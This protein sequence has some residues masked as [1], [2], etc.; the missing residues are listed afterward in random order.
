MRKLL[1]CLLSLFYISACHVFQSHLDLTA[2]T[3]A[4]PTHIFSGNWQDAWIIHIEDY[5]PETSGK[6]SKAVPVR[7]IFLYNLSAKMMDS[8]ATLTKKQLVSWADCASETS[9]YRGVQK[10]VFAADPTK[11]TYDQLL[12]LIT[13][14][15]TGKWSAKTG[16]SL[17][18]LTAKP[19]IIHRTLFTEWRFGSG[20]M[21]PANLCKAQLV[22]SHR[23]E[24]LNA[25]KVK[26]PLKALQQAR[27][28]QPPICGVALATEKEFAKLSD[29][30]RKAIWRQWWLQD[31]LKAAPKPRSVP[32]NLQHI[33]PNYL[34]TTGEAPLSGD[35]LLKAIQARL[36]S[37]SGN[38][39]IDSALFVLDSIVKKNLD[40]TPRRLPRASDSPG[41]SRSL[42][43]PTREWKDAL[44]Y[45]W[46]LGYNVSEA[47][48]LPPPNTTHLGDSASQPPLRILKHP[49]PTGDTINVYP[50][51]SIDQLRK[52]WLRK[53][54]S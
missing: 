54:G 43:A 41:A 31:S 14:M 44:Q 6:N 19:D 26:D 37:L 38:I 20:V 4:F 22:P 25:Q 2:P 24:D 36:I 28:V 30:A 9:S 51:S 5:P 29:S 8:L 53:R 18:A 49:L 13:L 35:T 7:R 16:I 39:N 12:D 17:S 32:D 50:D 47:T 3:I 42:V 52:G 23:G 11:N 46:S 10:W 45:L 48:R 27:H 34:Y 21:K 15:T 1:L 40:G 33:P